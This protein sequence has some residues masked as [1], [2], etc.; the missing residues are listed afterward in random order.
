MQGEWYV[1]SLGLVFHQ[2]STPTGQLSAEDPS[3]LGMAQPPNGRLLG[4]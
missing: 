3:T 4:P 1:L 2:A